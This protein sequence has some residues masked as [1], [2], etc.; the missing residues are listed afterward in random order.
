MTYAL[1]LITVM[2][3]SSGDW[4]LAANVES[5]HQSINSCRYRGQ[6]MEVQQEYAIR[7]WLCV[8]ANGEIIGG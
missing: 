6:V 3:H 8:P 5:Y 7:R 2:T 4:L 1:I